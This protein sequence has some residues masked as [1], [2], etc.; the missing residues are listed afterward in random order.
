MRA[1]NV[2]W[3]VDNCRFFLMQT[4]SSLGSRLCCC[5]LDGMWKLSPVNE[6]VSVLIT[7]HQLQ[8]S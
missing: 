3:V 1:I 2:R 5:M 7:I 8:A 6:R 4:I